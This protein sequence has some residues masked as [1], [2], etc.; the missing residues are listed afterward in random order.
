MNWHHVIILRQLKKQALSLHYFDSSLSITRAGLF[1]GII[2]ISAFGLFDSQL[3]PDNYL[4]LYLIRFVF[5]I[6]SLVI[7]LLLTYIKR[8]T[9][10]L[11]LLSFSAALIGFFG[12]LACMAHAEGNGGAQSIYFIGL[13]L[14]IS[15]CPMLLALNT[16][17]TVIAVSIAIII[18][19]LEI[20]K[21]ACVETDLF[22]CTVFLEQL[23]FLFTAGFLGSVLQFII[24]TLQEKDKGN[25][26]QLTRK[27][28][29]MEKSAADLKKLD[30]IKN[31]LLSIISH[32]IKGPLASI[33]GIL[34]LYSSNIIS[35]DEF[36]EHSKKLDLLLNNTS[37]LLDN[38]LYW[39]IYQ[40][41]DI[42]L[43]LKESNVHSL[44]NENFG[45]YLFAAE[46]K[47]THLIN[48]VDE[49]LTAQLD[50]NLINLVLR[51]LV[52]NAIKFTEE[53]RII[54]S[55]HRDLNNILSI[56][57]QDTGLGMSDEQIQKIY[58]WSE[59][60]SVTG[61][62]DEKGTGIGL[63]ICKEFVEKH[64]GQ[65]K[66]ESVQY[67]GTKITIELPVEKPQIQSNLYSNS[68]TKH[69]LEYAVI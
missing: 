44:V 12:M 32:D 22:A 2:L 42:P 38:L 59:R 19:T 46:A 23:A 13:I 67:K 25:I 6:P 18:F 4:A 62:R 66:V 49:S 27:K 58:Q 3:L 17:F 30:E 11:Q 7:C 14:L 28:I 41:T 9:K 45:L 50:K 8:V 10:Y 29:Q 16:F 5:V 15:F 55:A 40:G 63:I 21:T 39:S 1:T 47:S 61:T 64:G 43:S 35:H 65:L 37:S 68:T 26:I 34:R 56:T 52:S 51:N 48:L 54:V 33:R 20:N 60:N 24:R 31:K 69:K 53:G 36:K 57:M